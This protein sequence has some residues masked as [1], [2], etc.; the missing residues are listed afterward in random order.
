MKLTIGIAACA[1]ALVATHAVALDKAATTPSGRPEMIFAYT[2]VDQAVASVS[3]KCMDRGWMVTQQLPGQVVC[4]IPMGVFQ[5][6][7]TQ[8]LIGNSYSSPPKQFIRISMAQTGDHTRVQTQTWAETQMA[9]GQMQHHQ[10][11]DDNTYNA[12][13]V[14]MGEAGAQFP[15][16][17]TFTGAAYLGVEGEAA[18]WQDGRRSA[19]G[20]RITK[21]TSGSPSARMG[22]QVGDII[23]KINN[24]GFRDDAGFLAQLDR[25]RIGQPLALLIVRAGQNQTLSG[26]AEGRPTITTLVRPNEIPDGQNGVGMQLAAAALGGVDQALTAMGATR[27]TIPATQIGPE[28]PKAETDLE[29]MRRE[30]AEAAARLAEAEARAAEGATAKPQ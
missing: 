23:G 4:E 7:L 17:T 18:Q 9:F 13:M 15:V 10:Y 30:A 5:S 3:S 26:T 6:A 19:Y 20:W 28:V 16:G 14:F 21:V 11:T 1:V 25:A 8:M 2:P 12:S 24:R 27:R 22:V 29:R